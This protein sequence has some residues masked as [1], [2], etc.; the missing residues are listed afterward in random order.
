M[1]IYELNRK[2]YKDVFPFKAFSILPPIPEK[3]N[4]A[5]SSSSVS[6]P[7]CHISLLIFLQISLAF[8]KISFSSSVKLTLQLVLVI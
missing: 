3:K 5:S 4:A 7:L 1:R 6:F 2:I 8:F